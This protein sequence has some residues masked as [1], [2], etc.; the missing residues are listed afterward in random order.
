MTRQRFGNNGVE[1]YRWY[2]GRLPRTSG[3]IPV[4]HCHGLFGSAATIMT[5]DWIDDFKAV[6]NTGHPLSTS[7]Q[8]G[9]STWA[10]DA[11][12][13]RVSADLTQI[14]SD[15]GTRT[16]RTA[17]IGDSMGAL[18]ALNWAWRNPG[19]PRAI[20][21]RSPVVSMEAFYNRNAGFQ[22]AMDSAYGGHSGF[23]AALP[24][25]DPLQ[26]LDLIRPF[27]DRIALWYAT[28]DDYTPISEI[29]SFAAL[30]GAHLFIVEGEHEATI[31]TVPPDQPA[32]WMFKEIIERKASVWDWGVSDWGG[33]QEVPITNAVSGVE[34][35]VEIVPGN[36]R[37]GMW[38]AVSNV[39]GNDR[40]VYQLPDFQAVD[41]EIVNLLDGGEAQLMQQGNFHRLFVDD[42]GAATAHVAWQNI[43]FG[44]PWIINVGVWVWDVDNS[45]GDTGFDTNQ[46]GGYTVPALEIGTGGRVLSA[47]RAGG[48][49]TAVC[50]FNQ[51]P[52][53]GDHILLRD[54]DVSAFNGPVFVISEVGDNYIKFPMA[55]TDLAAAGDGAFSNFDRVFPFWLMTRCTGPSP[56]LCSLK[57]W[58]GSQEDEPAWGDPYYGTT[59]SWETGH[60]SGYGGAGFLIAHPGANRSL[61][62]GRV[63][64]HEL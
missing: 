10:N 30:V 16:D 59:I 55:G 46:T 25:H 43:V 12:I 58:Q 51:R 6:A 19:K 22:G 9:G 52:R 26:N 15:L 50:D 60:Y 61:V 41:S 18:L 37:R 5:P 23:L 32:F 17:L 49:V 40:R 3:T 54:M 53:V 1:N 7:D 39:N 24:T 47:S 38:T 63:E 44:V 21:L 62:Q 11:S 2:A 64:A 57:A 27:G 42:N 4:L 45:A 20:A 56:S 33:L 14:A 8:G 31:T 34:K 36:G 35:T 13:A 28:S 48:V 29:E